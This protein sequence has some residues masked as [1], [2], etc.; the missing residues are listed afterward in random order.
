MC[1][2][3]LTP[4]ENESFP[5]L[6]VFLMDDSPVAM[7]YTANNDAPRTAKVVEIESMNQVVDCNTVSLEVYRGRDQTVNNGFSLN[8]S[9]T[10]MMGRL[11]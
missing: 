8:N 5:R 2:F 1:S 4:N 9:G 7:T 10:V 11:N 6:A 3:T